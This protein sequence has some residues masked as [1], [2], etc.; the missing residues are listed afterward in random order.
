MIYLCNKIPIYTKDLYLQEIL[1]SIGFFNEA[2]AL[3]LI[4]L[5]G[6]LSGTLL[7]TFAFLS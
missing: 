7:L 3:S 4:F 1:D 6:V 2:L 5:S